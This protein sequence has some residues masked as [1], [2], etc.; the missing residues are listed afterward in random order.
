MRFRCRRANSTEATSGCEAW[1]IHS[2]GG[3]EELQ[4]S[5]VREP[6]I[7][8]PDQVLVKVQAASV[9]PLDLGM[10]GN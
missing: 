6:T 2:Y 9:N 8:K 4:K 1:Q 3:L 10:I 5:S 7:T